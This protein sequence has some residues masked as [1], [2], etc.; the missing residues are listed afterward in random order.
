MPNNP[1]HHW[2]DSSVWTMG[3]CMH[4]IVFINM[5]VSKARF[6]SIFVDEVISMDCQSWLGVHVYLVDGWKCNLTNLGIGGQWWYN[7]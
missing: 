6:I 3:K 4:N 2:N 7:K 1:Q 5:V